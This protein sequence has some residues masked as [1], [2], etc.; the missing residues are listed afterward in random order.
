MTKKIRIDEIGDY[1]EEKLDKLLRGVVLLTN[2]AVKKQ[3]PVDLGRFR[4]SW[5]IGEGGPKPGELGPGDYRGQLNTEMKA[6]NYTA[7][8]EKFGKN[9]SIHNNLPY[10]EK[11]AYAAGGSGSK[12]EQRYD[13]RREVETW[14]TP[15]QGSS[16]QTGG[17]GW[18]D[19]I[20][21]EKTK[22]VDKAWKKIVRE[23]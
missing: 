2:T 6:V 3:S 5:Q 23:D 1:A 21:K 4:M 12:K 10:A 16:V 22:M 13:P 17:P 15:G 18:L 11:L 9:Y 8:R 19:L 7:G 20:T 14:G